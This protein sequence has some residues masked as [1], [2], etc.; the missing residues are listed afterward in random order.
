MNVAYDQVTNDQFTE[1]VTGLKGYKYYVDLMIRSI[2]RYLEGFFLNYW[3]SRKPM[4]R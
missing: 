1:H 3:K 4:R 2:I